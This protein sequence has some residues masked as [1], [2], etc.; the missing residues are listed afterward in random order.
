VL[1][2]LLYAPLDPSGLIPIQTMKAVDYDK[3]KRGTTPKFNISVSHGQSMRVFDLDGMQQ[4][5][6][7]F[8]VSC[9]ALALRPLSRRC[10]YRRILLSLSMA[11]SIDRSLASHTRLT[12][13]G[14]AVCV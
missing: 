10:V 1:T 12:L 5:D 3:G 13:V 11:R 8:L 2:P 14:S 4:R 7:D 6:T 9:D